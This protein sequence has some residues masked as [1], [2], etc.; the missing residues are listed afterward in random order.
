[1]AIQ[2]SRV[3]LAAVARAPGVAKLAARLWCAVAAR[4]RHQPQP[5][6]LLLEMNRRLGIRLT[7]KT[8][9]VNGDRIEVDPTDFVGSEILKNG[10]YEP[11][12]V[13]LVSRVL[14]AGAV[15]V[16]VGANFGQYTLIASQIVGEAG[17]VHAFEPAPDTL[18]ILVRNVK[19]CGRRNVVCN[20]TALLD[21]S[22]PACLFLSDD[23]GLNSLG[24]TGRVAQD[25]RVDVA[26]TTLSDY[27]DAR[28]LTRLDLIKI[29]CEGAELPVL[30]G[31]RSVLERW[32]PAV[33]L[34]FS[35]HA[36]A[37]GYSPGDM[38]AFLEL[39]GYRLFLIDRTPMSLVTPDAAMV[40]HLGS[41]N[42]LALHTTRVDSWASR[43]VVTSA[44][45]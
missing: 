26:T 40:D 33:V 9:L 3:V 10:C 27:V 34:E 43:G 5:H 38:C 45:S 4:R 15:F 29:D 44:A 42:V 28:H 1:M 20:G 12:T 31:A 24:Q 36:R 22:G 37:F 18:A 32:R 30:R 14:T 23:S 2:P 13:E 25:R 17:E 6:W 39:L 21:T 8:S 35:V 16:D 7:R 11:E 19:R 41:L